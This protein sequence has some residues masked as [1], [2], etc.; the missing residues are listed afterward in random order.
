MICRAP[1]SKWTE[2]GRVFASAPKSRPNRL[3]IFGEIVLHGIWIVVSRTR[4]AVRGLLP[5]MH[6]GGRACLSDCRFTNT[7]LVS[8]VQWLMFCSYS[9][10]YLRRGAWQLNVNNWF[11]DFQQ[12][13]L[14]IFVSGQTV[15]TTIRSHLNNVKFPVFSRVLMTRI[16]RER[17]V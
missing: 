6:A 13:F 10:M 9:Y 8:V 17:R 15:G 12:L 16:I 5:L 1:K 14:F 4:H 11:N 3:L 7:C 2:S